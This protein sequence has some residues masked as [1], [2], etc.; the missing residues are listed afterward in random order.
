MIDKTL[1]C[2]YNF[3]SGSNIKY[4]FFFLQVQFVE[5]VE[6]FYASS[7]ED[8]HGPWEE[9]ARDRCRFQRRVQEVEET[10]SYCLSPTFRLVVFQ[11]LFNAS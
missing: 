5:E 11:R 1:Q 3:Y 6:E 8:R 2:F 4:L 7:D 10:I 9:I